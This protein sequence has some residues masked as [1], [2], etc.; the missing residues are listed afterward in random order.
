MQSLV[1]YLTPQLTWT[2]ALLVILLDD[3]H[4]NYGEARVGPQRSAKIKVHFGFLRSPDWFS[5][6]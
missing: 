2:I 6:I 4:L 1:Q 5:A 3:T